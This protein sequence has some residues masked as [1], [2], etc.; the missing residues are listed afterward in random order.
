MTLIDF[1]F[2]RRKLPSTRTTPNAIELK[3]KRSVS[4]CVPIS[5]TK[6]TE[7]EVDERCLN[8]KSSSIRNM[9][10][11]R[12]RQLSPIGAT[13]FKYNHH[14][15]QEKE[16]Q[17]DQ[18]QEQRQ[19]QNE[20]QNQEQEQRQDQ[21]KEQEQ[22]S[23]ENFNQRP[24]EMVKDIDF[25]ES[26]VRSMQRSQ[27]VELESLK[28]DGLLL[29]IKHHETQINTHC[30][31][32]YFGNI[33]NSMGSELTKDTPG[34]RINKLTTISMDN[35]TIMMGP[36]MADTCCCP[37]ITVNNTVNGRQDIDNRRITD[38]NSMMRPSIALTLNR[39]DSNIVRSQTREVQRGERD[40]GAGVSM[41]SGLLTVP[42]AYQDS[43]YCR[44]AAKLSMI[45]NWH[46]ITGTTTNKAITN[47]TITNQDNYDSETSLFLKTTSGRINPLRGQ[48][49]S[50][51]LYGSGMHRKQ[52]RRYT[53]IGDLKAFN[54]QHLTVKGQQQQQQQQETSPCSLQRHQTIR[55]Y[56]SYSSSLLSRNSSR[57]GRIIQL[58][59]KATKVLGVVFFT[60]VI[61]W[62]PFF[63]LNLLPSIC[64]D[65]EDHI[66]HWVFDTVTWLGYAS[67]MVNPIFYTIFNKVFRQAFKKVLLCRYASSGRTP[68]WRL[69]R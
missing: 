52:Q 69:D 13:A 2:I 14:H 46:P 1:L 39:S 22:Q 60:F 63:I 50:P 5:S 40:A 67:S 38:M 41:T 28:D 26:A 25:G 49:Y 27:S 44:P 11:L 57:H 21:N 66:E 29:P 3:R 62:S 9:S 43:C 58:E 37:S 48:P 19:A 24:P 53:S 61:L 10:P 59:Q 18:K 47:T 33:G 36:T 15:H 6:Q 20:E 7:G 65:C 32:P 4:I 56:Q 23:I 68:R 54:A 55:S 51:Q 42:S 17:K 16:Q 31:C 64:G 34:K 30:T 35:E 8:R 45:T 12:M